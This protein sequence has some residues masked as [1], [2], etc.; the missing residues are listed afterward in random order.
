MVI[1]DKYV[2]GG[3][4]LN[5]K[6]LWE[7]DLDKFNWDKSKRIVVQ[8][9]IEM[10]FPEDYYA[11]FD[12]YGGIEGVREIIKTIPYLSPLDT[13]FVCLF[14]NLQKEELKCYIKKQLKPQ[15][16]NS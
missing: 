6:L 11:I 3:H 7:Y 5:P 4:K 8:R 2:P 10:G 12:M 1:F 16:W 9:V 13:H 14:F 15:L